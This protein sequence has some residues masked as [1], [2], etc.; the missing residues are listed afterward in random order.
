MTLVNKAFTAPHVVTKLSLQEQRRLGE[1]AHTTGVLSQT[2]TSSAERTGRSTEDEG[3]HVKE[4]LRRMQGASLQ[5]GQQP[6]WE[7]MGQVGKRGQ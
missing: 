6:G 7:L 2:D 4:Q 5:D 3:R 1:T